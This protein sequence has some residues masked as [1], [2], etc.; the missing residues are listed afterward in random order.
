MNKYVILS[1]CGVLFTTL[2][3]LLFE[4]QPFFKFTFLIAGI[5]LAAYGVLQES[6]RKK[7]R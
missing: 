7:N 1:I 5:V 3:L 2:G 4:D 6:K